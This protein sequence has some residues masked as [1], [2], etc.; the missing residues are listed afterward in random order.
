MAMSTE[1]QRVFWVWAD[2]RSRC[3]NP[4]HKAFKNYGAR[5]VTV[6]QEWHD[7]KTFCS[8]MGPRPQGASLDRIDNNAGYSKGNC[9]WA[10]RKTQN[11][12][13][14][15]C[16]FIDVDGEAI[17]LRE[18][19]RRANIPYRPIVKRIQ[20]LGWPLEVAISA[21]IGSRLSRYAVAA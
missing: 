10:D 21:P 12:N 5:G 17:T 13:R 14:R 19:C 18:Y 6:C 2:M 16:I 1:Q 3:A 20:D 8:D 4:R 9:R 11:S 7:F 15:N